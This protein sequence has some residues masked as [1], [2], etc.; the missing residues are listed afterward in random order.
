MISKR[1]L[2]PAGKRK[3]EHRLG[4]HATLRRL[5][6]RN[7][8]AVV[9]ISVGLVVT[10]LGLYRHHAVESFHIQRSHN[11]GDT[12]DSAAAAAAVLRHP[13]SRSKE[14]H[15]TE[16]VLLSNEIN[17]GE[18]GVRKIDGVAS[19]SQN[20]PPSQQQQQQDGLQNPPQPD[21]NHGGEPLQQQ[22]HSMTEFWILE[23]DLGH[24]RIRLRP[25][26]S[27]ESVA[28]IQ[29]VVDT[30]ECQECH[31]YRAEKHSLL[32][33]IVQSATVSLPTVHGNC[34]LPQNDTQPEVCHGPIM[35][36]GMV[37]WAGGILGPSFFIDSYERPA[38]FWGHSYT[39]TY[40]SATMLFVSLAHGR[41]M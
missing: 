31:F 8:G 6:V 38:D 26:L 23:T 37:G 35:T 28:Y 39:G 41:K 25:D 34:P 13:K 30:N 3:N 7:L 32:Q 12:G 22:Q 29:Q 24:L 19:D 27:P 20:H 2:L 5:L 10:L 15:T 21:D 1:S 40:L 14:D 4:R 9:L 33:G 16:G 36:H 11:N 17:P 18:G